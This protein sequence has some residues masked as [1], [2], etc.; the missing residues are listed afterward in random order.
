MRAYKLSSDEWGGDGKLLEIVADLLF[1]RRGESIET[2]RKRV[3]GE[4]YAAWDKAER[5]RAT[6]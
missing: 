4:I 1:I 3:F 5:D 6:K 2:E